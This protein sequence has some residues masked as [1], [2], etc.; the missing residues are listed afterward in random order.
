MTPQRLCFRGPLSKRYSGPLGLQT[1]SHFAIETL[2][3]MD[4]TTGSQPDLVAL[5]HLFV[6]VQQHSNK[7]LP[8]LVDEKIQYQLCNMMYSK[9]YAQ[10]NLAF[11]F[12]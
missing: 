2:F 4:L 12:F 10:Y 1:N 5:V 11:F 8:I 9:S 3:Q 7:L 6:E